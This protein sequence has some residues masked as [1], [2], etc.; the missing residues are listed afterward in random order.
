MVLRLFNVQLHLILAF[1]SGQI[2]GGTCGCDL[3][4]EKHNVKGFAFG[5]EDIAMNGTFCFY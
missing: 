5:N 4:P 3:C 2:L 1:Q